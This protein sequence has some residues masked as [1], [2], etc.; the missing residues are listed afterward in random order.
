LPAFSGF[1][2]ERDRRRTPWP[3]PKLAGVYVEDP[4]HQDGKMPLG[5]T[6]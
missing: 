2:F 3:G 5:G 4:D 1:W 6:G